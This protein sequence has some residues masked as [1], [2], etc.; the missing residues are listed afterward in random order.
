MGINKA[1]LAKEINGTI[2]YIYPKTTADIVEYTDNQTVEEKLNE[3]SDR[4]GN[5]NISESLTGYYTKNEIDDMMSYTPITVSTTVSPT[6]AE[7]GQ[8]VDVTVSW[9]ASK[10]P[11]TLTV[12]GTAIT[13]PIAI[14]SKVFNGVTATKS[15]AVRATDQGTIGKPPATASAS[16][17]INFY[18]AIYY[19]V[20][21]IPNEINSAFVTGLTHTLRSSVVNST[22]YT[23]NITSGKYGW[24]ACPATSSTSST[25]S[26]TFK[27]GGFEGGLE[28]V[29][30]I[31]VT[32]AY[33]RTLSYKVFRTTNPSLGSTTVIVS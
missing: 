18:N 16:A 23:M 5:I 29:A 24:I 12:D 4:V 22:G 8:S 7:N 20:A 13:P 11:A 28:L 19:G 17:T 3:L 26:P 33:N 9:N 27:I 6:T 31:D 14:G 21:A 30:T 1:T 10:T 32:N 15:Y 25:S 2:E